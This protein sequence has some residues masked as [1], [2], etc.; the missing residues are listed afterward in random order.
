MA[1]DKIIPRFLVSDKDE[2]LLEEGA[3]TDALNVTISEDGDGTEGVIKNVKGTEAARVEPGTFSDFTNNDALVGI[4]SVADDVDS[5]IYFFV[6]DE[7]G[8]TQDAIYR[9]NTA[10]NR[11]RLVFRS[12][13]F[14]F[15]KDNL[16]KADLVKRDFAG[17][18]TNQT[19]I[20]FTDGVNPPRKINVD[21]AIAG[22]YD[23]MSDSSLDFALSTVK[24]APNMPPTF[25]FSRDAKVE[26]NNFTRNV[27]QFATQVIYK[28]GEESAISPYSKIAVSRSVA[29][30]GAESYAGPLND[31]NVCII[32]INWDPSIDSSDYISDVRS[33][34]LL[35]REGNDGAFFEIDEF[36]PLEDLTRNIYG[37]NVDVYD[38]SSR[39]Y[40]FYNEGVYAAVDTQTVNKLYD[41][42][43]LTAKGQAIAGNRLFYSNYT[44]S[45]DNVD[46]AAVI[47]VNYEKPL[48]D[49]DS[50]YGSGSGSNS[51]D[52]GGTTNNGDIEIDL[53]TGDFDWEAGVQ[54]T[55]SSVVQSGTTVRLE[56]GYEPVGKFYRASNGVLTLDAVV[57]DGFDLKIKFG[58]ASLQSIPLVAVDPDPTVISHFVTEEDL[59]VEELA[60]LIKDH[61]ENDG[62]FLSKSYTASLT[63]QVTSATGSTDYS[64][65]DLVNISATVN[66]YY[67]LNDVSAVTTNAA[68]FVIKPYI[69]LATLSNVNELS[70]TF[71]VTTQDFLGV[72][73][74]QSDLSY[75]I[76]NT[77]G[78]VTNPQV[79]ATAQ[80]LISSFK[81]GSTHELGVVY[82]DKF[83]RSG[84]V[85]KIG[86]FNVKPFSNRT[87]NE[88]GP[89]SINVRWTSQPPSWATSYQLVYPGASTYESILSYTVG[90]GIQLWTLVTTTLR[91]KGGSMCL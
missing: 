84:F 32:K 76:T 2:R 82:Y 89:V 69:Y 28:D 56:F 64:V 3:M 86:S 13:W 85:N 79:F 53:L 8:S 68:D 55:Y 65:N 59:T 4:G 15:D 9:Y 75:D 11:Y 42:V 78:Y 39:D 20:Y 72:S 91:T 5:Y 30:Q 31:D 67:S 54:D 44:E 60:E 26:V 74:E 19:V 88:E 23:N 63:G 83:N 49:P 10:D 51:I 16:I 22:D 41:N 80:P 48:G 73:D 57:D 34:R 24:A 58:Y 81:A 70:E 52:E 62:E 35:G 40:R 71:T 77:G 17:N 29:Y 36:S 6:A 43:P 1:I 46:A 21:R 90:G 45:R 33:I 50:S 14:N 27:F 25:R 37:N 66:V 18:G 38:Y 7:S 47:T 12:S 87:T 61:F